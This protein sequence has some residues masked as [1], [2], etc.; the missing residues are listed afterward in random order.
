MLAE[1]SMPLIRIAVEPDVLGEK[2]FEKPAE[3]SR[4]NAALLGLPVTLFPGAILAIG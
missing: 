3:A 2:M 1:S 4:S